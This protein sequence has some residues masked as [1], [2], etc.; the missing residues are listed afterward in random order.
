M[1]RKIRV[2]TFFRQGRLTSPVAGRPPIASTHRNCGGSLKPSLQP[3]A[4]RPG[5]HLLRP[6]LFLAP[7]QGPKGHPP[8]FAFAELAFG[9]PLRFICYCRCQWQNP[10]HNSRLLVYQLAARDPSSTRADDS[11][12]A[13]PNWLDFL[14]PPGLASDSSK[15]R[16]Y[17][18]QYFACIRIKIRFGHKIAA[19]TD[20]RGRGASRHLYQRRHVQD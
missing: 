9:K 1:L 15:P 14:R 4:N 10:F 17:R 16:G 5:K 13:P 20:E 19:L 7:S 2:K 8:L 18:P 12:P 3:L 6:W 11:R